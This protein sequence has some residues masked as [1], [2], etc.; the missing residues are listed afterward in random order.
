MKL[1]ESTKETLYIIY[2]NN[3]AMTKEEIYNLKDADFKRALLEEHTIIDFNGIEGEEPENIEEVCIKLFDLMATNAP[4]IGPGGKD[5]VKLQAI[6]FVGV[7]KEH[8][9][10]IAQYEAVTQTWIAE[11]GEDS[12][13]TFGEPSGIEGTITI[14]P[15][16]VS[17]HQLQRCYITFDSSGLFNGIKWMV[18]KDWVTGKYNVEKL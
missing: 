7:W 11:V 17:F 8:Y 14:H 6:R 5:F 10:R 1:E 15:Q 2:L 9:K 18:E 4:I 13:I 12:V 16:S 3:T